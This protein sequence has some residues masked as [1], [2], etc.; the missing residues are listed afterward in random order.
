[1]LPLTYGSVVNINQVAPVCIPCNTW[2]HGPTRLSFPNCISIGT[3]VFA[4]LTAESLRT[5]Q[6]ADISPQIVPSRGV[7]VSPS[8]TWSLGPTRVNTP[9]G[10]LISSAVFA[11]LT[12]ATPGVTIG[13]IYVLRS[14]PTAMRP[15]H[16]CYNCLLS[17]VQVT[18]YIDSFIKLR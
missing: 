8:N 5:L 2:F 4:Q 13:R 15:N 16:C 14:R 10:I 6:W 17:A 18:S 11:W 7:S 12:I 3:A 9:N 1:M